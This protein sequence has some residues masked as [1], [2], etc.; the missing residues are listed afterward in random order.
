MKYAIPTA[1]G[2]LSPHFGQSTD[3][4]LLEVDSRGKVT[5]RENLTV[6]AH[7]CGSLPQE[8]AQRGVGVVLAGGMGMGPRLAFQS[9]NIAVV[10]GVSEP[11]PLRAAALHAAG[12]LTSGQN[13]CER[14]DTTCDH[15]H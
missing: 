7:S 13:V 2:R 5:S 12:A 8:L 10:L 1:Q 14:T 3:F 11:D 15:H 6:A 9:F 4:L